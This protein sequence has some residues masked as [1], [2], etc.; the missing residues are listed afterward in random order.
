MAAVCSNSG[1]LPAQ[2]WSCRDVM[3]VEYSDA[4][5]V[6]SPDEHLI[7]ADLALKHW[8]SGERNRRLFI[9]RK[10]ISVE[11]PHYRVLQNEVDLSNALTERGFTVVEPET[12]S[13][14][15][16]IDLYASAEYI[17]SLGGSALFNMVFCAPGTKVVTIESSD[18]FI[19]THSRLLSSLGLDYGIIFG[20]Q[21]PSDPAPVHKRWTIDVDRACAAIEKFM[22]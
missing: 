4:D 17:V 16:Q 13:I 2:Y 8:V 12:L 9:S 7:F 19:H 22:S 18:Y 11:H 5:L 14:E 10:S 3:T 20:E 15:E 21:D 1:T 6:I